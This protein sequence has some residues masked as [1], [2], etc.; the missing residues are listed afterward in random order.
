M[1]TFTRLYPLTLLAA[2][3][4]VSATQ[5]AEGRELQELLP[6]PV[7][8]ACEIVEGPDLYSSD[9]LYEYI[10]G[11]A[12]A[13]ISY[14][15]QQLVHQIYLCG[16]VELTC[17]I[18]RLESPVDAFG[19]YSIER[20]RDG[21]FIEL[22]IE[23]FKEGSILNFVSDEYYIKLA[24]YADRLDPSARLVEF[25]RKIELQVPG[26]SD[27]PKMF[28]LLPSVGLVAHSQ[29]YVN[30]APL[31]HQFLSPGF[32]AEYDLGGRT[33]TVLLSPS[34]QERAA[35]EKL[36]LL[37]EHLSKTGNLGVLEGLGEGA[38]QADTRYEGK[39][40]GLR[41]GRFAVVVVEPPEDFRTFLE[42][43]L[44]GIGEQEE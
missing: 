27:L 12:E 20:S 35:E 13:F 24:A 44:R 21:E 34:P 39:I 22:G 10:N 41:R 11:A 31:G 43:L 33:T 26:S 42:S 18:Y 4:A 19:I 30:R 32:M 14:N 3:F 1:L 28:S 38:F 36:D 23:G 5:K 6:D 29:T 37:Q 40:L 15:F 17:D 2:V 9:S 7:A 16:E 25:A 8:A